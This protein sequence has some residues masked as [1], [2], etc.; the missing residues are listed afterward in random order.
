MGYS[1]SFKGTL[2]FAKEPTRKELAELKKWLG[3]D[4]REHGFDGFGQNNWGKHLDLE[5]TPDFDGVRWNGSE[6]TCELH[7]AV[8]F[9]TARMR[10]KFPKFAFCGSLKATGEEAD[11]RWELVMRDGIAV[12]VDDPPQGRKVRCPHCERTFVLE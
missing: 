9:V 2:A 6:K 5:L 8:N 4:V 11:D 7:E 1:T 12:K 3:E 10:E